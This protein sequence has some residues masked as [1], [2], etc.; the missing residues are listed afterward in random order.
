MVYDTSCRAVEIL[1]EVQFHCPIAYRKLC[2]RLVENELLQAQRVHQSGQVA[3]G[4]APLRRKLLH[5]SKVTVKC[6]GVNN[7]D[8]FGSKTRP[9]LSSIV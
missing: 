1:S 3:P 5:P 2:P 8:K 4:T 6:K 9:C 7:S